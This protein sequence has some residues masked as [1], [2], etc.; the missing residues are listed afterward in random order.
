MVASEEKEKDNLLSGIANTD[1]LSPKS[2]SS[3]TE[4]VKAIQN[5]ADEP[6]ENVVENPK[7]YITLFKKWYVKETTL[8]SQFTTILTLFKYNKTYKETHMAI[9]NEWLEAF[10]AAKAVVDTRYETNKPTERQEKGYVPYENIVRARDALPEGHIHRLLLDMYTYLR[11]M[12]CEYARVAL[13]KNRAP[14]DEEKREPNYIVMTRNSAKMRI[15]F[16]KT[17]KH[18][19][20]FDIKLPKELY[21]DLKMSLVT[22]PRDW[23]FVNSEGE[24]YNSNLYT[25]WT[26]RVF[27]SIFKRP[28]TVALIRHA[29]INTIDFNTLSI[30]DKKEIATSMGHTIETQDRYR[31]LFDDK[32][33]E[34]DCV[35][36]A[37]DKAGKSET[38][39]EK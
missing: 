34:C 16:F 20:A 9:Y 38:A 23:L 30:K 12:R 18:H 3:Y 15:E 31:L 35:C 24:P 33:A 29:Y 25:K 10:T 32:K 17:R 19:D 21:Y 39:D 8:K 6:I 1:A 5:R 4:L 28:M 7:K 22:N 14:A 2:K 26:M 11:P 13:Y 36:T 37:K 27:A